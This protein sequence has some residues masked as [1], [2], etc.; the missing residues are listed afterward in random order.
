M[1]GLTR[2][3]LSAES[4]TAGFALQRSSLSDRLLGTLDVRWMKLDGDAE[5]SLEEGISFISRE[6]ALHASVE[7]R[8]L[9]AR[10]QAAGL[11]HLRHTD[12]RR[13]DLSVGA[14]SEI[15]GLENSIGIA[16]SRAL[17]ERLHIAIAVAGAVYDPVGGIPDPS[18]LGPVYERFLGPELA[19]HATPARARVA[20]LTGTWHAT[21]TTHLWARVLSSRVAPASEGTILPHRPTGERNGWSLSAGINLRN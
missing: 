15:D 13:S 17:L 9:A 21:A 12:R 20:S 4:I 1:W 18:G 3:R 11:L 19:L 10:W 14:R 7:V 2:R 5:R 8:W 6:S 16:I